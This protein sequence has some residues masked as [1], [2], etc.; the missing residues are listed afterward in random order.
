MRRRTVHRMHMKRKERCL[1]VLRIVGVTAAAGAACAVAVCAVCMI[2]NAPGL[3]IR[4]IYVIGCEPVIAEDVLA[5]AEPCRNENIVA[6][7]LRALRKRI[8]RNA[9]IERA[10]IRRQY[11]DTL[12]ISVRV[13]TARAV[14][15]LDEPFLVDASGIVFTRA[16]GHH[17][18]LP[19]LC[20]LTR[21][22]F[23]HD[24]S[25]ASRMIDGALQIIEG[26]QACAL[27][28]DGYVRLTC[29]RELGYTLQ[30]EPN[31]P[32]I[33]LGFDDYAFKLAA[34]PRM[35][36]DLRSRGLRARYI[37]LHSHERAFVKLAGQDGDRRQA[38]AVRTAGADLPS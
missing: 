27:P 18:D 36:A 34:L 17:T 25:R 30:T 22:D 38:H 3:R 15:A 29:N 14:L 16:S 2:Y 13:R 19:V 4:H 31:G 35:L 24:A 6:I 12:S 33:Y 23:E 1:R 8:E 9:W 10:V 11:P 20:G 5:N 37:H 21:A 7:D 26:L 32:E 28:L